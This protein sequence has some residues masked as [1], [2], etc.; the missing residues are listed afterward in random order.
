MTLPDLLEEKIQ[1]S[2]AELD[3]LLESLA[4]PKVTKDQRNFAKLSKRHKHLSLLS[5]SY[6]EYLSTQS[7]LE[8]ALE[9]IDGTQDEDEKQSLEA[10]SIILTEKSEGLVKKIVELL[11]PS[12]PDDDKNVI[13]EI[14]GAEGGEEANLFARE[15]Y[16]MYSAYA[17]KM[18]WKAELLMAQES[19]MGGFDEVIFLLKGD[20]VWKYL[21][22]EG[23]PHRVQRVPDTESQGRVHTSSATVSVLPEVDEVEVEIN[24]ADL[25]V[26]VYRSSG[27]GGQ[28]VNTTDSAVRI[29]HKPT[30]VTVSMQDEKSQLQNRNKAMQV[31]RSRIYEMEKQKREEERAQ[32]KRGQTK[33][34]GRSDKIRTYNFKGNRVTD[35]RLGLTLHKLDKVLAGEIDEILD[36]LIK[37]GT[38]Q[39]Q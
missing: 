18:G 9:L 12:D 1:A 29:T 31:L 2:L 22:Y 5:S 33:S 16:K 32:Q 4:D 27:P 3:E 6:D 15:L 24:E 35:H 39:Q 25:E 20:G 10:E 38:E 14:R 37:Y 23:G 19:P 30:G 21:K 26:D 17:S 34:G 28:S 7:D 13:V 8:V 11:V 36:A